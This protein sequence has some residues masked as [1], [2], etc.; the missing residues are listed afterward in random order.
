VGYRGVRQRATTALA[1]GLSRV[2]FPM[3]ALFG[4]SGIIVKILNSYDHSRCRRSRGVL[5]HRHH[6]RARD[7]VPQ[8]QTMNTKLYV[9]AFSI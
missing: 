4:A 8:A 5:E 3:V 9:Y 2:L 7:G 1:V 6:R